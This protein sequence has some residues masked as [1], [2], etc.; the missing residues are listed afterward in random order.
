MQHVAMFHHN[1]VL[2]MK[3]S[4]HETNAYILLVMCYMAKIQLYPL[5]AIHKYMCRYI[6]YGTVAEKNKKKTAV[7]NTEYLFCHV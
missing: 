3:C 2:F 4:S 6:C 5:E 1:L 7:V